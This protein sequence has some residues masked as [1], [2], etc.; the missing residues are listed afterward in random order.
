[1]RSAGS[2]LRFAGAELAEVLS[3][4]GDYIGEELECDA[5]KRLAFEMSVT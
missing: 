1:L 3:G 5:S 4:F 2:V